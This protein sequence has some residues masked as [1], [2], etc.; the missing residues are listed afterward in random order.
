MKNFKQKLVLF[1]VIA[2]FAVTFVLPVH[3][4][5]SAPAPV[6]S[7]SGGGFLEIAAGLSGPAIAIVAAFLAILKGVLIIILGIAGAFLE[8]MLALNISLLPATMDAARIGWVI[9]RDMANSLFIL[10]ILW[11]AFTIIFSVE[12]YGGRKLLVKVIVA[13]LLINFSLAMVTIVFGFTNMLASVFAKSMPEGHV[14][15]FLADKFQVQN[16]DQRQTQTEI[17]KTQKTIAEMDKAGG[18]LMAPSVQDT[19]LASIG[20]HPVQAQAVGGTTGALIGCAAGFW[21]PVVGCLAGGIVGGII[22]GLFETTLTGP[23]GL[24]NSALLLALNNVFLILTIV[25]FTLGAVVLLIRLVYMIVLSVIA[26]V[27]ILAWAAP[28][29]QGHTFFEWWSKELFNKA[30]FA[31]LFYFFIY[32]ALLMM[33]QSKSVAIIDP[34]TDANRYIVVISSIAFLYIAVI[35]SRKAGGAVTEA[36]LDTGKKLGLLAA[37]GVG[38]MAGKVIMPRLGAAG[39][40]I[41]ERVSKVE[42]PYLRGGMSVLRI[43]QGARGL[44]RRGRGVIDEEQKKLSGA[45]DD[46]LK[47]MYGETLF[48]TRKSAI[49]QEL[50][51]RKK[52]AASDDIQ[53]YSGANAVKQR[54]AAVEQLR[55]LG[56]GQHLA[57]LKADP[58]IARAKD[59][60]TKE[61]D[62]ILADKNFQNIPAIK[63]LTSEG[64]RRDAAAIYMAWQKNDQPSDIGNMD[65]KSAFNPNT[66]VG[67]SNVTHEALSTQIVVE[68]I[69]KNAGFASKLAETDQ[70][71]ATNVAGYMNTEEG[72]TQYKQSAEPQS[73]NSLASTLGRNLGFRISTELPDRPDSVLIQDFNGVSGRFDAMQKKLEN[74]EKQPLDRRPSPRETKKNIDLWRNMLSEL[75][76]IRDE[77]KNRNLSESQKNILAPIPTVLFDRFG[78]LM[79]QEIERMHAEEDKKKKTAGTRPAAGGTTGGTGPAPRGTTT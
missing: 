58:S 57:I 17:Q 71:R 54:Q 63:K 62:K 60:S 4:A 28:G 37:G 23:S 50:A 32:L 69:A 70:T 56:G 1:L 72:K 14:S 49:T 9:M 53:A 46:E 43:P 76:L 75:S 77:I 65:L 52:L 44:A 55:P 73:F 36:V 26:P 31:P 22:G 66:R 45:T 10:I 33:Q 8:N 5:D 64:D 61:V 6:T 30:L 51:K 21:A 24:W 38:G 59:F 19:A 18:I 42:N 13:A 3:A 25:A 40:R 27:A 74:I 34:S 68:K 35:V 41:E 20:I 16:L 2:F 11:I 7:S 79:A 29:K 15:D 47:R 67:G 78:S 12:E 39:A 48:Q